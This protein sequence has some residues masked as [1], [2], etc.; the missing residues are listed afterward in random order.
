MAVAAVLQDR[1]MLPEEWPAPLRMAHVT[2]LINA[3]L[4][5]LGRVGGAVG[6]VAVRAGELPF[7]QRHVR[8]ALERGLSL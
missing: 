1:R 4:L 7:S 8:T 2:G 3:C 6:I 5:E